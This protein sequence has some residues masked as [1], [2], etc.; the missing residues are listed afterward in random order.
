MVDRGSS[1]SD[2]MFNSNIGFKTMGLVYIR[3]SF[4]EILN[5]KKESITIISSN[6]RNLKLHIHD[7]KKVVFASDF[8]LDEKITVGRNGVVI[9]EIKLENN[10]A[11]IDNMYVFDGDKMYMSTPKLEKRTELK[12]S[13]FCH[14]E[15]GIGETD[16]FA[17][18]GISFD[19]KEF[20]AMEFT[21]NSLFTVRFAGNSFRKSIAVFMKRKGHDNIQPAEDS[22]TRQSIT[23]VLFFGSTSNLAATGTFM[24]N[25]QFEMNEHMLNFVSTVGDKK[26]SVGRNRKVLFQIQLINN[27]VLIDEDYEFDGQKCFAS[28]P[29]FPRPLKE[30]SEF[31]HF[32]VDAERKHNLVNFTISLRNGAFLN[33]ALT[34][35]ALL[36]ISIDYPAYQTSFGEIQRALTDGI[37]AVEQENQIVPQ[38]ETVKQMP[39]FVMPKIYIEKVPNQA[40]D[41]DPVKYYIKKMVM[42]KN[43]MK[44]FF[45]C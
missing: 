40:A 31:C 21:K 43:G 41:A 34:H 12:E 28:M 22:W 3:G 35:V 16:L 45:G 1:L 15:I 19:R 37:Q 24:R 38:I 10:T 7:S 9:S 33:M 4:G 39:P 27:R 44:D 6:G 36:A 11:E 26:I 20:L 29:K 14:F 32:D 2:K 8:L 18:I 42:T 30:K 25:S 5:S 13:K 23:S 17:E